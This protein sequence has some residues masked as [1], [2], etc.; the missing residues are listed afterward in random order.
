MSPRSAQLGLDQ[1][2]DKRYYF[3][4]V[5]HVLQGDLG[6]SMINYRDVRGEIA[7][8][9]PIPSSSPS[10]P[11]SSPSL[12]HPDRDLFGDQRN[13]VFDYYRH[14]RVGGRGYR[15]RTLAGADVDPLL[16]GAAALAPL[17][18]HQNIAT[19]AWSI[20]LST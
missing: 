1:P 4:L 15:S 20:N 2:L 12:F 10:R 18:G 8:R 7:G 6:K 14:R 16:R 9:L 11:S 3:R 19:A 13:S 5:A 17:G